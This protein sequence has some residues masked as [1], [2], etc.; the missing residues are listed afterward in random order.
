MVGQR[1]YNAG[2]P[3]FS[4]S[5]RD[6]LSDVRPAI[7]EGRIIKC[8]PSQLITD[9]LVQ[10]GQ[11][12]G[13]MFDEN[14]RLVGIS[15]SNIKWKSQIYPK[16]N[17]AVPV[18]AIATTIKEYSRN[19]GKLLLK[20]HSKQAKEKTNAIIYL[21]DKKVLHGLIAPESIQRMW[22][23]KRPQIMTLSKL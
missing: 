10:S 17:S 14:G 5:S 20:F 11:S 21:L 9:G 1:I 12:G 2:Y 3:Y 13:P 7:F 4:P 18:A 19:G 23:L 16:L 22:S 15:V 6:T 8:H